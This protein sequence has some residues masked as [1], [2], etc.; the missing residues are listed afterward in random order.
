MS[1]ENSEEAELAEVS[2]EEVALIEISEGEFVK[3]LKE[4]IAVAKKI[5]SK[6]IYQASKDLMKTYRK[7][8]KLEASGTKLKYYYD[9]VSGSLKINYFTETELQVREKEKAPYNWLI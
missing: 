6:D 9:K 2:S 5:D 3:M 1:L 4:R 7:W 8:K